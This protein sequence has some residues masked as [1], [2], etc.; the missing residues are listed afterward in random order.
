MA[1]N[2]FYIDPNSKFSFIFDLIIFCLTIYNSIAIPYSLAKNIKVCKDE[3]FSFFGLFFY[4][5]EIFNIIDTILGFF[6]AYHNYE[7]QL[8]KK[9]GLIIIHY[10]KSWFLVDL[11]TS[12]LFYDIFNSYEHKCNE[13]Y[14]TEIHNL[15]YLFVCIN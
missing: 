13:Y 7:E 10:I 11:I 15:H 5:P 14:N 2:D 4:I 12:I 1:S 9:S 3:N 8:I 6:R